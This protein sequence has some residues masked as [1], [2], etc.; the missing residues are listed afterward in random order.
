MNV[1]HAFKHISSI[2]VSALLAATLP[3]SAQ[4]S[5][6][7][8]VAAAAPLP[9]Y[10]VVSI[11]ENKSGSNGT[12]F[13]TEDATWV[14]T[15][16]SLAS[17]LTNAYNI[18]ST[19]M[20]GLPKWASAIRFDVN[21]KISDPD[22]DV[23]RKLSKE[24]RSAMLLA[25][26]SDRFRLKAH[27]ETKTLPVYDLVIAKGGLKLRQNNSYPGQ[28]GDPSSP[29]FKGTFRVRNSELTATGIPMSVFAYYFASRA[30]RTII[31]KTGLK[32]KYDL[33]LK[34][35]PDDQPVPDNGSGDRA[36]DL[37]TA[38]QEQLGL[39]LESSKGPVDTLVVDHVEMPTE[40]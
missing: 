40:N 18:R 8:T 9:V 32:G 11:H 25:F 35:T 34:W 10:D 17:L 14:A 29:D 4:Q 19:L 39:K 27:I 30:G 33:S 20:S 5:P 37:F 23:L 2:S 22:I 3:L 21:A 36:P 24:Q 13:D 26:L 6:Q 12:S 31:D 38:L 15:N 28:S 7:A 1:A 16:V